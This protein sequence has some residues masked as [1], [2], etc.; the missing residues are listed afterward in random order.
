M[1][2]LVSP[3][4]GSMLELKS[5]CAMMAAAPGKYSVILILT[6]HRSRS[7]AVRRRFFLFG[8]LLLGVPGGLPLSLQS[9]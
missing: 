3:L 9:Q 5:G 7:R 8:S 1:L 6:S 2:L 4:L